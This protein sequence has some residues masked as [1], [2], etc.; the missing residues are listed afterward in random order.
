MRPRF[1]ALFFEVVENIIK[2]QRT[3]CPEDQEHGQGKSKVAHAV[4]DKGLA[5]GAGVAHPILTLIKPEADQQERAQTHPFPAEEEH[6]VVVAAYQN[7]H[8]DD[9]EI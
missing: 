9:E 8:G 4:D 6:E 1:A 5:S 7:E 2:S 3:G